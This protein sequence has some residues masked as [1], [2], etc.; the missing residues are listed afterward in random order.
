[1]A[2]NENEPH[3]ADQPWPQAKGLAT[4]AHRFVS[5]FLYAVM[6]GEFI[7]LLAERQW[8]S[9]A[10]V[11]ALFAI[12]LMPVVLNQRLK[13]VIPAEFQLLVV[14]FAFAALFMG[15]IRGLYTAIWWWDIALHF[16]SGLLL[17]ILGFLT[18]Y[19]MNENERVQI[20]LRP[21]F[22]ALFAFI[23]AVTAGALWE[24]I[25]FSLDQTFGF[26]M[27][28]PMFG[29]PSGLTDTMWDLIVDALGA[30]SVSLLGWWYMSRQKRSFIEAMILKFIA[31]NPQLFRRKAGS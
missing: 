4:R 7:I 6:T 19:V 25:E 26:T 18:I 5:A 22:A 9:A 2:E 8:Q 1:M 29:D 24:I 17:G 27:Q 15:S 13:V 20:Y 28:R 21:K 3:A 12:F 16:C 31:R 30:G 14:L 11:L 10:I 23:F